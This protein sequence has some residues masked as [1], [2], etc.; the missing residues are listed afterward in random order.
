MTKYLHFFLLSFD[1][2]IRKSRSI[3][4]WFTVFYVTGNLNMSKYVPSFNTIKKKSAKFETFLNIFIP[5]YHRK[6]VDFQRAKLTYD[7]ISHF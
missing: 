6:N 5:Y 7:Q 3:K 2:K 4:T 1:I